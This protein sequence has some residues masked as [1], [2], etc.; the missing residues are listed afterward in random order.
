MA[1]AK[2]KLHLDHVKLTVENATDEV[3]HA[4][5]LQVEGTA[6]RNIVANDQIDTGFM[7]NSGYTQSKVS[8]TFADTWLAGEDKK[9]SQLP[10]PQNGAL[11][12][13]SA[14]YSIFQ[15]MM[16][17]FLRTAADEV[18][19]QAKGIAEPIYRKAI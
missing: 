1:D 14:L 12:H 10:A 17:P 9:A 13:W 4:L 2:V 19:G 5:A 7:L 18:A 8:S 16:Q 6:K 3:L 11:V 15:E